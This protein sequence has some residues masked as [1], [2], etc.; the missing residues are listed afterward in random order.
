MA[1]LIQNFTQYIV[2]IF[3]KYRKIIFF[4]F[5]WIKMDNKFKLNIKIIQII[6]FSNENNIIHKLSN[7]KIT[8]QKLLLVILNIIQ[9]IN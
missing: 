7:L 8:N 4:Y 2:L 9:R 3:K 6:M 5:V 1:Y